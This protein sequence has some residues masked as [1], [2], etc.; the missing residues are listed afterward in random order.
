MKGLKRDKDQIIEAWNIITESIRDLLKGKEKFNWKG[1]ME[2]FATFAIIGF[3][4]G[5][6]VYFLYFQTQKDKCQGFIL[7]IITLNTVGLIMG[8]LGG[9]NFEKKYE[10]IFGLGIFEIRRRE[11]EKTKDRHI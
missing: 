8:F 9:L 6:F 4:L 1:F 5:V 11:D 10:I 2:T 7:S 3:F